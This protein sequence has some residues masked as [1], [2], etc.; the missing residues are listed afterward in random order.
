LLVRL[1]EI[2]G[3]PLLHTY[4]SVWMR[5]FNDIEETHSTTP[6][7]V[8]FR[9]PAPER[10]WVT[11]AGAVLDSAALALSALDT[12]KPQPD[13]ELCMAPQ[14]PWSSD[15]PI[16]FNRLPVTRRRARSRLRPHRAE[17]ASGPR[18]GAV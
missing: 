2:R 6:I 17:A 10:S 18:R 5:W 11:A 16:H 14:A 13:A 12:D 3:L 7:L 9:S 1:L 8:Y 4:W 15:R